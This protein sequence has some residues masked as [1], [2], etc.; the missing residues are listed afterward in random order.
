MK[1]LKL[2]LGDF[3]KGATKSKLYNL[4]KNAVVY[5]RVSSKEQMDTNK[6]LEWQKSAC[7]KYAKDQNFRILEYF[8]GTYESAKSDERKE[9]SKM[10]KFVKSQKVNTISAIIVYSYDRFSRTGPGSIYISS[11]L[12][13]LGI[14]VLSATQPTDPDSISGSFQEWLQYLLGHMDNENRRKKSVDGMTEKMLRGEWMGICPM[15]YSYDKN[16]KEQTIVIN[17]Q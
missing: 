4:L 17:Q 5:T 12:K 13:K 16:A 14:S 10:L 11:E 8:G 6:S 7:E 15:G 2:T 9:F 1:N 3:A